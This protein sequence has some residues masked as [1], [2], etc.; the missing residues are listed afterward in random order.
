MKK[1][2]YVLVISF[3]SFSSY[4]STPINL[5]YPLMG[6]ILVAQVGLVLEKTDIL[7]KHGFK[8][9]VSA[10]GTGKELKT[11]ML[12]NK[13]DVIL[14]SESNFVVLRGNNFE[15]YAFST[16]GSAG[17]LAL[18]VKSDGKINNLTDLRGKKIGAIFG[19]TV[20]KDA[21]EWKNQIDSKGIELINLSSVAA[22]LSA[23]DAGTIEAGMVWDPFLENA[24][25]SKKFKTLGQKEF[26]LVNI[27]SADYFKKNPN[28]EQ[29]I[30]D[31]LKEA[32]FYLVQHKNEVN[33]WYSNLIKID[34]SV[35]DR[36]TS[37]NKNY[38]V[39]KMNEIDLKINAELKNKMNSVNDFFFQEKVISQKAVLENYIH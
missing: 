23:I 29:K 28:V 25:T 11:A 22:I 33:Q 31:S 35:I 19:T 30:N 10:L 1:I 8:P 36:A 4:A 7:K 3:F 34:E 9:T 15:S 20:H 39:K 13:A 6:T 38:N 17:R 21:L 5:S 2:I 26:D 16:M 12:G 18:V 32:I 14:T 24:L 37:I 27:V